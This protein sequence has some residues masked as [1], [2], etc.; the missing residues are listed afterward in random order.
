VQHDAADQLDVVMTKAD[1]PPA[2]LA[3][4]RKRFDQQIVQRFARSQ[5]LAKP[6]GL[7]SQLRVRHRLVLGLQVIDGV[8]NGLQ[9]ADVTSVGR[10]EQRRHAAFDS[11]EKAA[12]YQADD[13][14][15]TFQG[16]HGLLLSV[17]GM[18]AV[19]FEQ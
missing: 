8:H 3:A 18:Q 6:D 10:A 17:A 15:N 1:E 14:P 4:D 13:F 19:L 7:L 2:A 12:E 9:S 5:A 11:F 16:F